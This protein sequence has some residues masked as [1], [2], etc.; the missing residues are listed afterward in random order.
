MAALA[1]ASV[2]G[3]FGCMAAFCFACAGRVA[4]GERHLAAA[5]ALLVLGAVAL[6]LA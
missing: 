2:A 6:I 5:A 4:G 1:L 3:S